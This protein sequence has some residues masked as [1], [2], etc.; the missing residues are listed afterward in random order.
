MCYI[1]SKNH[2]Y[3]EPHFHLMAHGMNGPFETDFAK[4][5]RKF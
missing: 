4:I 1:E 3:I 5:F 2:I